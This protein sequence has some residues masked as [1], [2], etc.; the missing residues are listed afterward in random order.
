MAKYFSLGLDF[1]TNSARALIVELKT[2]KEIATAVANYP[3][4]QAGIILD[5]RDPNVARQNPND[6]LQAMTEC[7]RAVLR[8]AKSASG[9][10]ADR[11]VGIG[12]DATA[13]TPLPVDAKGVPLASDRRFKKNINAMA[14][15]WKDHT[16]FAEAE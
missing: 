3:S 15:L 1:G 9:F 14:W 5:R 7:T 11:I 13:S 8:K 4:G 6:W 12:I 2:G 10:A 16:S